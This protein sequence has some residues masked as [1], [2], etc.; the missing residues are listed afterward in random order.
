MNDSS[1]KKEMKGVTSGEVK[2]DAS[3]GVVTSSN[4]AVIASDATLAVPSKSQRKKSPPQ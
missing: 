4:K 1:G 3:K 2:S